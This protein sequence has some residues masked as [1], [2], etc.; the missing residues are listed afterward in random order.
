VAV[1]LP[2]L[3]NGNPIFVD[4]STYQLHIRVWDTFTTRHLDAGLD[5]PL[6][7]TWSTFV[8]NDDAR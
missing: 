8:F 1:T 6:W 5:R 4:D 7:T 3:Y 2:K